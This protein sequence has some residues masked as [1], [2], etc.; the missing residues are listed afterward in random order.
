MSEI[1]TFRVDRRYFYDVYDDVVHG[2]SRSV[3]FRCYNNPAFPVIRWIAFG[4]N[5][6]RIIKKEPTVEVHD[7]E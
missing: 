1:V 4:R 3:R 2:S 7:W 6:G 5:H